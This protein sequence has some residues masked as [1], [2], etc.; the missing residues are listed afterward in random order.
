MLKW[1]IRRQLASFEKQYGY[2]AGYMRHV[3]DADLGAFLKFARAANVGRYRK[4][5]PKDVYVA[6]A[7]VGSLTADCGPCTQLGVTMALREGVSGKTLAAVLRGDDAAMT[8]DV[9]LGAHFAR[10]VLARDAAADPLREEIL[11]RWGPRAVISLGLALVASQL[12]PTF[13]YALGYGHACQ[14]IDVEGR[15]ITPRRIELA[16]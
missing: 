3:L 5:V 11:R 10:A 2:D 15:I 8:E 12:Y 1:F 16:A 7:L 4:D 6:A 14:R 13:K 9:R